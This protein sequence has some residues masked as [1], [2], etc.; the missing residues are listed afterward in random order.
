MLVAPMDVTRQWLAVCLV[1]EVVSIWLWYSLCEGTKPRNSVSEAQWCSRVPTPLQSVPREHNGTELDVMNTRTVGHRK[2]GFLGLVGFFFS[3]CCCHSPQEAL[4]SHW[5]SGAREEIR[6]AVVRDTLRRVCHVEPSRPQCSAACKVVVARRCQVWGK[7]RTCIQGSP[8][9]RAVCVHSA[10]K[11]VWRWWSPPGCRRVLPGWMTLGA[12]CAASIQD[13]Q[14]SPSAS[15]RWLYLSSVLRVW[16]CWQGAWFRGSDR[17]G[18][19]CVL[20]WQR[21]TE[22]QADTPG[23]GRWIL[24]GSEIWS[25]LLDVPQVWGCGDR[26]GCGL[27]DHDGKADQTER[28]GRWREGSAV[29]LSGSWGGGGSLKLWLR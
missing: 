28:A 14:R 25:L 2:L 23:I 18:G 24:F 21:R 7:T 9:R 10:W 13:C 27:V 6:A 16:A 29:D 17:P 22:H 5:K 15:F 8:Q 4:F 26:G 19:H 12:G 1:P 3:H 11:T 20:W